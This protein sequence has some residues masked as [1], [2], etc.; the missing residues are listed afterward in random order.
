MP[1][2]KIGHDIKC[3]CTIIS[4]EWRTEIFVL[5]CY[6]VLFCGVGRTQGDEKK[7]RQE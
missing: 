3:W 1:F 2:C 7:V 4:G 6:H 5:G